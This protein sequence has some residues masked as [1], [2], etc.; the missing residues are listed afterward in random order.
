MTVIAVLSDPPRAGLVLTELVEDGPLTRAEA[1]TLYEAM[2][3]DAID[4][5]H[6]SGNML[7]VNYRDDETLPPEHLTETEPLAEIR[8]IAAD[9]L[10]DLSDV[11]FERQVGSTHAARVGNTITHLLREEGVQSAAVLDPAAP[12][13]GRT[14]LDGAAMQLRTNEVV[15]GPASRGRIYYAGFTEPI[16]FTDAFEPPTVQTLT[17]RAVDAELHT[18]F[19]DVQPLIERG[20]DLASVVALLRSRVAAERIVPAET[21]AA[22]YDLGLAVDRTGDGVQLQRRET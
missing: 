18:E 11:R 14:V 1:A 5:V 3:R 22:I 8:A 12:L 17:D 16:D 13:V 2:V 7:L 19:L 4:A 6:R 15:L 21:A 10:G 9:T 20:S